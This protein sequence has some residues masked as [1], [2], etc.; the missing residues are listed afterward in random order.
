MADEKSFAELL[1]SLKSEIHWKVSLHDETKQIYR[2]VSRSFFEPLSL[3]ACK[4]EIRSRL[5]LAAPTTISNLVTAI[6]EDQGR[7]FDD[8]LFCESR[9]RAIG[10]INGVFD[11]QTGKLRPYQ[12]SDFVLDP[13]P[14]HLPEQRSKSAE[15]WF[16]SILMQWVGEDTADW[17]VNALAYMIFIFPNTEQV[18]LNFFGSG[19]NG[20]SLCLEILER[21]VGDKKCI[22]CDLKH[23]NRFTGDTVQD[24]W[25]VIGRDS[26][27]E[28]SESAVSFIKTFS[29]DPK[30]LVEKKGG[31]SFDTLNQG[32]LIVSTNSLI[33]SKDRSY[34]WYRRLL[35]IPFPNVFARNEK[36]RQEIFQRLPEIIRLLAHR[37]YLYHHNEASLWGSVPK[38]VKELLKETRIMNDRVAAFWEGYFFKKV[39]TDD[40]SGWSLDWKKIHLAD[41]WTMT[42]MYDCFVRW[43]EQ[44][45]GDMPVLPSMKTFCGQ[46]GEF[47]S[48]EAGR[49]FTYKRTESGRIISLKSEFAAIW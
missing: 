26:S 46:Y 47:L 9:K 29:G 16:L 19:A 33:Q 38:S 20:K 42:Q 27:S 45:F 48:G 21:A 3:T 23:I 31:A 37:A 30:V 43:H 17:F 1:E 4:M 44:E 32:K 22:G 5:H 24:K 13:L 12:S 25:L 40:L 10:F 41:G 39:E 15:K 2:Q 14:H 18:W 8:A 11:L 49:Y 28:V 34:A 36:F 7:L 6:T 35:P